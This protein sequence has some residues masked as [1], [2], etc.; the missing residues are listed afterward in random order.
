[1]HPIRDSYSPAFLDEHAHTG[2]PATTSSAVPDHPVAYS[3]ARH[4]TVAEFVRHRDHARFQAEV[5]RDI[6]ALVEF[7][8]DMVDTVIH[9]ESWRQKFFDL[10]AHGRHL[11]YGAEDAR[12]MYGQGAPCLSRLAS[13][14]RETGLSVE[15]RRTELRQLAPQLTVC[16]PGAI[17]ALQCCLGRLDPA[18]N[19][20]PGKWRSVVEQII[21][22]AAVDTVEITY[23]HEF[24]EARLA[25]R[26]YVAGLKHKLYQALELP[27]PLPED[28]FIHKHHADALVQRCAAAL[29]PMIAPGAVARVLAEEYLQ[30]FSDALRDKVRVHGPITSLTVDQV[31]DC[32]VPLET[33]FGPAPP[34]HA[35]IRE[36][37]EDGGGECLTDASL[38][39][40]HLLDLMRSAGTLDPRCRPETVAGW[41][42]VP[43][44]GGPTM[45]CRLQSLDGLFWMEE[46]GH[47]RPVDAA[48]LARVD[49]SALREPL[50]ETAIA[51][52]SLAMVTTL[53]KPEW[54]LSGN[55][56]DRLIARLG[57]ARVGALIARRQSGDPW[58]DAVLDWWVSAQAARDPMRPP[59][60]QLLWTDERG[61]RSIAPAQ[62]RDLLDQ[63]S[64][65]A[66]STSA[67]QTGLS[68]LLTTAL[69]A[70]QAPAGPASA[71]GDMRTGR[72]MSVVQPLRLWWSAVGE[73]LRARPPSLTPEE[74]VSVLTTTSSPALVPLVHC[75]TLA[76]GDIV[77]VFLE[78]LAELQRDRLLPSSQLI[79]RLKSPELAPDGLTAL[80]AGFGLPRLEMWQR[81]IVKA[82]VQGHLPRETVRDM[83]LGSEP[84]LAIALL[85][86]TLGSGA[87]RDLRG[88][89]STL[90]E[91]TARG[92]LLPAELQSV[93]SS[94]WSLARARPPAGERELRC[95]KTLTSFWFGKTVDLCVNHRVSVADAAAALRRPVAAGQ[96]QLDFLRE[97]WGRHLIKAGLRAVCPTERIRIVPDPPEPAIALLRRQ[98][99]GSVIGMDGLT[100]C[101]LIRGLRDMG[102]TDLVIDHRDELREVMQVLDF[103]REDIA[104]ALGPDISTCTVL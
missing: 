11:A 86:N 33:E 42:W 93:L 28:R 21:E 25:Q 65:G 91:A 43:I 49:A 90:E 69:M 83:I 22:Q 102:R 35:L 2:R 67:L 101:R 81:F 34:R 51:N 96:Q 92:V 29:R 54:L 68:D 95:W 26:H 87:I 64:S 14:I 45:R 60:G 74:L 41:S 5:R 72:T 39:A 27:W 71:V 94:P 66:L 4:G 17:E 99:L 18:R 85:D 19:C 13:L 47:R 88:Y 50:V 7:A 55:I 77:H 104:A 78:G 58:H 97:P 23:G 61:R 36:R 6:D 57:M 44:A 76:D 30:R 80:L 24:V 70:R 100:P 84:A 12:L 89:F 79:E 32:L 31:M 40:V 82:V 59:D 62:I 38:V 20:L 9:L 48:D 103:T 73:G 75:L 15:S 52:S 37:S 63:R 53:A 98:L 56:G 3:P 16:A 46:S 8:G 1:M 10:D